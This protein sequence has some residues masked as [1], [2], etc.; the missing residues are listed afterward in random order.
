VG[1]SA[2]LALGQGCDESQLAIITH[3]QLQEKEGRLQK[4]GGI[5][6][7]LRGLNLFSNIDFGGKSLI[8]EFLLPNLP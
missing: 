5:K 8:T 2:R 3:Q 4:R 6:A 7:A 1:T